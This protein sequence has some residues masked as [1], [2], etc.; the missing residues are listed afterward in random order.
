MDD[1]RIP[2]KRSYIEKSIDVRGKSYKI[3]MINALLVNITFGQYFRLMVF[4]YFQLTIGQ[5][6]L[7]RYMWI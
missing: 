4:Y 5:T 7:R 6:L 1:G 3:S 2:E